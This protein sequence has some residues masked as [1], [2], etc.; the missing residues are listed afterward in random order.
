ME[1]A[2][3]AGSIIKDRSL[4]YEIEGCVLGPTGRIQKSV[5]SEAA[6]LGTYTELPQILETGRVDILV[7]TDLDIVRGEVLG[8]A[9]LCEQYFVE[10]KIIPSYFQIFISALNLETLSGVPV[11]GVHKLPLD[12]TW[13]RILKRMLDITGSIV[14]LALSAPI[15]LI[16]GYLIR[17][18][19]PGPIFYRQ[20]RMARHGKLFEIFKLRS[21]RLDAEKHGPQWSKK[22]DDRRLKIGKVLREWNLDE[23]PQFW[24]V[25][26]GEMSLVGPRPE[27]PEF[28]EKF[29]N[30]IPNYH[31]RHLSKPGMT[32]WAQ[33]NGHRGES[34][35]N[36]RIQADLY[37]LEHWSI[38]LDI[39]IMILTFWRRKNAG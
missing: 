31:M 11:L 23:L 20:T 14:G 13:N 35:L 2:N 3:L 6:I 37:Y 8:L 30:E 16:C 33:I 26:K 7:L 5:A 18:E 34:D 32:G 38:W 22:G 21:M 28:I 29:K 10:F 9:S 17:R 36:D 25:L 15:L 39:Q 24:N 1:S 12:H 4:P 19:S 27:R